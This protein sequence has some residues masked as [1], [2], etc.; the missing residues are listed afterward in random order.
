[1]KPEKE[2]KYLLLFKGIKKYVFVLGLIFIVPWIFVLILDL[3]Y[4]NKKDESIF[5]YRG[6]LCLFVPSGCE[7]FQN[8]SADL[9][10][11]CQEGK[12]ALFE[13]IGPSDFKHSYPTILNSNSLDEMFYDEVSYAGNIYKLQ[14]RY[15]NG[16]KFVYL[17]DCKSKEE[18]IYKLKKAAPKTPAESPN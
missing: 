9:N 11:Y 10:Y 17:V 18:I 16:R 1:M 12:I 5:P 15:F 8:T 14:S 7:V 2:K 13:F 6:D 3:F 4:I